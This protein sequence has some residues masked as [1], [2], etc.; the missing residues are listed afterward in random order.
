MSSA[1]SRTGLMAGNRRFATLLSL[2]PMA[3]LVASGCGGKSELETDALV[4]PAS[5]GGGGVITVVSYG[6]ATG[7]ATG[8][9]TSTK[10]PPSSGGLAS[11][12]KPPSTGGRTA[13]AGTDVQGGKTGYGGRK[14]YGGFGGGSL[15]GRGGGSGQGGSGGAVAS[16]AAAGD[17]IPVAGQ[18]PTPTCPDYTS[19]AVPLTL[20]SALSSYADRYFPSCRA[21]KGTPDFELAWFAPGPDTYIIDT[22]GSATDTVLAAYG[23]L[24]GTAELL[25]N[26]D[27]AYGTSRQSRIVLEVTEPQYF[28]IVVDSY[29]AVAGG[30]QLKINRATDL[31][32]TTLP[33]TIPISVAGST[34]GQ[35]DH[36]T[37]TCNGKTSSSDFVY[38]YRAPTTGTYH[39]VAESSNFDAVL[40]LR[41]NGVAGKELAC[42]DDFTGSQPM[43]SYALSAGQTVAIVIDGFEGGSGDFRFYVTLD[44]SDSGSCCAP[45][46]TRV[47]CLDSAVSSCVCASQ[48]SCCRTVWDRICTA[49][50]ATLGC[51]TCLL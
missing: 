42:N 45:S 44:A 41:E 29:L 1:R 43:V 33:S 16:G 34:V 20:S 24:C 28:T 39:F 17:G 51:G 35:M 11:G 37:S 32:N 22:L 21:A 27:D 2:S 15:G 46:S 3:S 48:P 38:L 8:G 25:C 6:G 49:A 13:A 5:V 23:G 7:G 31:V 26:D 40:S 50:V 18:G 36:S 12:G 10:A 30:F 4:S 19:Q 9:R 47:G 14:A